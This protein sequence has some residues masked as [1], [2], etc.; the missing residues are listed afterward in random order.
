MS[1]ARKQ[2]TIG[3]MHPIYPHESTLP[4]ETA[5][6]RKTGMARMNH[7]DSLF[8]VSGSFARAS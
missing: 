4:N 5:G 3:P 6:F 8:S 7:Q 2:R 1:P